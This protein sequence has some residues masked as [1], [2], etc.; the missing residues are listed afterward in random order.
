MSEMWTQWR[1]ILN[2]EKKYFI[3]SI[4]ETVEGIEI[5]LENSTIGKNDKVKLLFN[6]DAYRKTEERYRLK[7]IGILN[8][9]YGSN[10]YGQWTFFKV[11]GSS[12][13]KWLEEESEGLFDS[14]DYFQFTIITDDE[15][16]DIISY[17]EP[18]I[19]LINSKF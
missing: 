6:S 14:K 11:V 13:M 3:K 4:S 8:K 17:N 15:M 12:Y 10:F 7:T 5:L 19:E 2:L 1:P 18:K 16:F 9:K